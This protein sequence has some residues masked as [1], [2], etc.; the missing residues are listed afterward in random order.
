MQ[1]P[2]KVLGAFIQINYILFSLLMFQLFLEQ[3]LLLQQQVC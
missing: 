2:D 3:K 1:I